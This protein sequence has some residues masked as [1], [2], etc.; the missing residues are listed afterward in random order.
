[1][2]S[3]TNKRP[4]SILLA[5]AEL[6]VRRGLRMRLMREAD[7]EVI[8]EA[9]TAACVMSLAQQLRP[10]L[11][12]LDVALLDGDAV[13]E[14]RMCAPESALVMLSLY[15][16]VAARSQAAASGV[17]LVAKHEPVH[18]LLSA[19]RSVAGPRPAS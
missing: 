14:L 17:V 4:I 12:L 11:V 16:D 10:D 18:K 2:E 7:F 19:I 13:E 5:D 1:V 15:D 6:A 8:G 9:G 3:E